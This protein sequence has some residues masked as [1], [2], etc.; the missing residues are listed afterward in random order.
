MF[1]SES[2]SL[3]VLEV[4]VHLQSPALLRA[5]SYFEFAFDDALTEDLSVDALPHD[6]RSHPAPASL[7]SIGDEWLRSGGFGV[8]RVPSAVIP[9][10][11]NFLINP[12]HP[13]F[14]EI[15]VEGP[16]ELEPDSRLGEAP[17]D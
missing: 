13:L 9:I 8:L 10:E 7:Q 16:F 11:R 3:A 12:E 1:A 14:S 6:W 17:S 2:L 15:S 4:L 5:Y